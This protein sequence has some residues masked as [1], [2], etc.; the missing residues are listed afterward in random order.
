[1][2]WAVY[3][4]VQKQ[5][6]KGMSSQ[7]ILLVL[8]IGAIALLMPVSRPG[9]VAELN[10]LEFWM[11]VFCCANTLIGYGAFAEALEHWEVSRVSAVLALAPLCTLAGMW[12]LERFAPQVI[13]PEGLNAASVVGA[14]LVVAGSALCALGAQESKQLEEV[15]PPEPPCV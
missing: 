14:L 15:R 8:Y 5:L 7:Q 12:L 10:A 6:L 2:L 1:V 3:G 13:E 11:L 4:L 9:S